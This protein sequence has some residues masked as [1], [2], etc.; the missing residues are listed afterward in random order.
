M[1]GCRGEYMDA[2]VMDLCSCK[3]G[4]VSSIWLLDVKQLCVTSF[5][6]CLTYVLIPAALSMSSFAKRMRLHIILLML[7]KK[8][9]L[10]LSVSRQLIF[11]YSLPL[12]VGATQLRGVSG[13]VCTGTQPLLSFPAAI[14]EVRKHI[15]SLFSPPPPPPSF[16]SSSI[17]LSLT[18]ISCGVGRWQAIHP[19]AE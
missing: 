12:E 3:E 7:H 13:L 5:C 4:N 8:N 16:S 18:L 19:S 1:S 14:E 11:P 2:F 10:R 9:P 17:S 6:V 15:L